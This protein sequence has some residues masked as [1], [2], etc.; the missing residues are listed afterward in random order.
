MAMDEKI[1][2]HNRVHYQSFSWQ[3][4]HAVADIQAFLGCLPT[5]ARI[6]SHVGLAEGE[7]TYQRE[8]FVVMIPQSDYP[9]FCSFLE[10]FGL[11]PPEDT[12]DTEDA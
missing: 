3:S 9:E 2:D 1:G 11:L 6:L 7:H 5:N 4:E 8:S 10:D 12:E